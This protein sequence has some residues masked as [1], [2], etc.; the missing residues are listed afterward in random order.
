MSD[1][2]LH[3]ET[4]PYVDILHQMELRDYKALVYACIFFLIKEVILITT[5]FDTNIFC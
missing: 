4:R 1:Q 2:F 5:M 3:S